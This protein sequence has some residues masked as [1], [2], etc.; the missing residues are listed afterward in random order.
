MRLGIV[1]APAIAVGEYVPAGFEP[2]NVTAG[3]RAQGWLGDHVGVGGTYVSEKRDDTDYKLS[4]VDVTLKAG[5]GTY[6]KAEYGETEARQTFDNLVS[7]DGGLSFVSQNASTDDMVKG[8]AKQVEVRTSF[9]ELTDGN[10]NADVGAYWR[11]KS[12]GFSATRVDS[13]VGNTE[14]GVDGSYTS[15][16]GVGVNVS[17][18]VNEQDDASLTESTTSTVQATVPIGSRV[19]LGAEVRHKDQDSTV[20]NTSE[21]TGGLRADVQLT[22]DVSV[23]GAVQG[24]IDASKGIEDNDLVTVGVQ[25]RVSENLNL[26]AEA[27]AGD[28]GEAVNIGAD[29]NLSDKQ[30]LTFGYTAD[31]DAGTRDR[32]DT[33]SIGSSRRVSN[34][35]EVFTEHQFNRSKNTADVAQVYGVNFAPTEHLKLA[36]SIQ[37]SR[38]DNKTGANTVR[39]AASIGVDYA[40]AALSYSGRLEHRIDRNTTKSKQWVTTNDVRYK[41]SS[42]ATVQARANLSVTKE[43]NVKAAKFAE[44]SLGGAYRPAFNDRLNILGRYTYLYDLGS[45]GQEGAGNDERSHV[46]ALEGIYALNRLWELG[47]KLSWKQGDVRLSRGSGEWL[48]TSVLLAVM[49]GRYH[50]TNK[51]DGVIDYRYLRVNETQDSRHGLLVGVD[52]HIGRNLKVGVGYNFTDFNDDLTNLDFQS[53]GWFVN[54]LGKY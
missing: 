20:T 35:T 13:G 22:P 9:S 39:D 42:R 3:A 48:R 43:D 33:F 8:D 15:N 37:S 25:A 1:I 32:K 21:T 46:F 23:Y 29:I 5:K 54:M 45:P 11:R 44:L 4:G 24:Q 10:V 38:I 47:G 50:I 16:G 31:T 41:V 40:K 2:K 6:I 28:R 52:R 53:K 26:R 49:R 12:A 17:V 18:A 30:N 7:T 34:R 36:L 27:A 51:W 14:Y 19:K